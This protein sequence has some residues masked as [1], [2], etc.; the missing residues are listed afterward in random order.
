VVLVEVEEVVG[1]EGAGEAAA[2]GGADVRL[3][4]RMAV[5]EVDRA[6]SLP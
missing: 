4:D 2:G 6:R 5:V 3:V 1:G